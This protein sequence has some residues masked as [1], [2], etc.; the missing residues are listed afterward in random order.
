MHLYKVENK[1]RHI[2]ELFSVVAFLNI[3]DIIFTK[4]AFALG[5]IEA[6]PIMALIYLKTGFIGLVIFKL[7][8][9][10]ILFFLL[11][12]KK[13]YRYSY[14]RNLLYICIVP[15]IGLTAYHIV[16]IATLI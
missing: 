8:F 7:S 3:L 5:C 11:K 15:Y 6:N 14:I 2:W 12:Y 9:V 16:N 10:F 1:E 4:I 13:N